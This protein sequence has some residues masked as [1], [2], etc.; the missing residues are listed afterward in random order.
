[1]SF[2][3]VLVS[4]DSCLNFTFDKEA[5]DTLTFLDVLVKKAESELF[6]FLYRK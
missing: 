2:L 4:L 3:P 6:T 5:D 1:M